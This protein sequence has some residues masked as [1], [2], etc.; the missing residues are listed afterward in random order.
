MEMG[1]PKD[2]VEK[3]MKAGSNNLSYGIHYLIN[4]DFTFMLGYT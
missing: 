1:S 3:A 4:V 2:Q